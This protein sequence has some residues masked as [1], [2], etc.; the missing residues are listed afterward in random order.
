MKQLRD[1]LYGVSLVQTIGSTDITVEHLAFD[2]REVKEGS[3]FVAIKGT[4]VDGHAFIE[5]ALEQGAKGIV[6]E[7]LPA[8]INEAI[9]YIQC[10]NSA[11][12]LGIMASNFYD[13]PSKKLQV[14]GVTGTNG[15]TTTVTLLYQLFGLLGYS[16]G[17]LSTVKNLIKDEER[18]ATHTTPDPLQLQELMAEMVKKGCTHCF[19]EVSSHALVQQRTAGIH[20][21]GAVFSNISRDHLDFHNTMDEYIKA[22]KML[23]DGLSSEAFALVNID[24]KRGRVMVQNTKATVHTFALKNPAE[25]KAKVLSNTLQGLEL[26]LD[27]QQVWFRM[28]GEFNAYNLLSVYAVA[29]LCEEQPEEVLTALSQVKPA[30]GR[31]EL[32]ENK[33]GIIALV[34]YAHTPDA[35]D[36]V[37]NTIS[38]FRTGNEQVIT[39]VGCGGDRDKGKRPEMA[40]IAC[41]FSDK[42]ILTAD[43]PRSEEPEAI[44]KD[45]QAGI[46]ISQK[47]KVLVITNRKE[48]IQ[49]AAMFAQK[50]DVVLVAGKGHET[51]QE[52][53]GVRHPFDD[54]KVLRDYFQST[55]TENS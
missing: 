54:R 31:M 16:C 12:A 39:V 1:I 24:D 17:L 20:F 11:R 5:K 13:N 47:Q 7:E 18:P 25:F 22:K 21:T 40:A 44:I 23:F 45:M 35:L 43:N 9:T 29:C 3:I 30:E 6:C 34:D 36:N 42:V 26:Q 4:Q 8:Q 33:K 49:A 38:S 19:M 52:I 53:K 14:I 48:A 15:K 50:H 28:M 37:L 55:K 46:P 41:Q 27:H 10:S 51:Y 2:S 32:V